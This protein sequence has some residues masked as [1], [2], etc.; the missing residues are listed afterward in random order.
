MRK[1]WTYAIASPTSLGIRIAPTEFQLVQDSE[2]VFLQ[3]TSAESN[4]LSIPAALGLP[5][6]ALAKFVKDDPIS[7]YIR[8]DMESRGITCANVFEERESPW[9]L[10]HPC[11]IASS[12]FGLRG[13]RVCNDRAG[14]LGRTVKAEDF[15]PETLFGK[16]G[17][18]I[19][20]VSGLICSLSEQSAQCCLDLAKIAK[21]Y[22]TLIS[23]DTNYRA[24]LWKG[25]EEVLL[26]KFHEIASIAD[27]LFGGDILVEKRE[28]AEPYFGLKFTDD[29]SRVEGAKFLL[30]KAQE[31]YPSAHTLV[32]TMR[33]VISVNQHSFGAV[34]LEKGCYT[35]LDPHTMLVYDRIGGG[36]AFA[37]GFLYSTVKGWEMEKRLAFGWGAPH[38]FPGLRMITAF[39]PGKTSSGSCRR[40]M[41]PG[42]AIKR[43]NN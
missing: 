23:F 24:S 30:K 40:R 38:S 43:F 31:G 28:K 32:S 42:S 27:I 22:G 25:R 16:E 3:A 41:R 5:V 4:T 14:E 34:V 29:K 19:L 8:R 13:P 9:G 35:T 17:V 11:N 20:H 39:L 2:T 36:D 15:D 10:R 37:G 6:K 18:A 26:A 1:K 21:K 33:E 12:G 7:R